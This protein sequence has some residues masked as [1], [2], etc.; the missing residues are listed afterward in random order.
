METSS[1]PS[2]SGQQS[3]R[4]AV[5][6]VAVCGLLLGYFV[7]RTFV[8]PL[9]RQYQLDFGE[10]QWIEPPQFG[11]V[12][13]FRRNI[14]L[15]AVP[16]QAWLELAATDNFEVLINGSTVGNETHVKTRVAGIYDI[17]RHL[18]PGTNVIAVSI[19]R[20]SYPGSAQLL[21]KGAVTEPGGE[22]I[23]IISDE[24]WRVTTKTGIV[25]GSEE[26]SS[27]FVDEALWP[28]AKRATIME[29]RIYIS[30]V[31]LNPLL[32][33]LPTSGNWILSENGG[34]QATFSTSVNA[35][36]AQQETW[37]Q[38]VSSGSLDLL[39]N[40]HLITPADISSSEG[41]QL[42]HLPSASVT[43]EEDG[44][45][46]GSPNGSTL[47]TAPGAATPPPVAYSLRTSS[48]T[49]VTPTPSPFGTTSL[50]RAYSPTSST[51]IPSSSKTRSPI[52][53]S[54]ARSRS[55]KVILYAY[56]ISHWIKKGPNTIVATVRSVD[57]PASFFANGFLVRNDGSVQRFETDSNWQVVQQLST[58]TKKIQHAIE[59]GKDGSAP[60]GYLPQKLA[61]PIDRSGFYN[62]AKACAVFLF[63]MVATA[64]I[65]V[66]ASALVARATGELLR[67][68]L[69]R[70]ALFHAPVIVGL[71]F[72]ILPNYDL[73]F[74]TNW[75]FHP[76]FVIGAML[77]LLAVRLFHFFP[78]RQAIQEI[79][80]RMPRIDRSLLPHALPYLLLAIIMALGLG[81]RCYGLGFMSF[82]HDEMGLISKS[83]GIYKLGFPYSVFAGEIRQ[84]TTYEAVPYPLA[85]SGLIFGHSEWAMRLPSCFM[86]TLC[87]GIIALM[88]RRMF[89]WRTGLIAALVY[90]CMPLNI[91]WAH[92]A[93]YPQQCQFMALLTFWLF[94]E[95]IKVRP[96]QHK[97]L[98]A[99]AVTF[100]LTYL[101]WEGSAFILP[102]LFVGLL[103][104]RW[105]E[106]WWLKEFHLYRCLFFMAAVVIAQYCS[107]TYASY[108]YLMLGSGL[109]NL[110]GPSLFFL[111]PAYQPLYY[112]DNLWLAENHVF[113]TI[114]AL[115]GILFCWG[116]R[117]F[118]Y[119]VA[120]PVTLSF[121][122]TN[123]LAA[124]SPRYCYY[125]QPLLILAGI[126][127]AVLLYDRLRS[128]AFQEGDS[129][130]ARGFAHATGLGLIA[131]LFLQSNESL[132]REY[133]LS[134]RGDDPGLM[135]RMNT[136][137]Y[138][139]R[140]V[141]R[142]VRSQL[143]PGDVLIPG[144]P[145]V[146]EY[147]TGT[148]G[149]YFLDT[150]FASKISYN[151]K[152]A[153]P[154]LADKFR[155]LPAI[156]NLT[157]LQEVTH[158]GGR[159]W[160]ID[161]PAGTSRR[162]QSADVAEYLDQNSKVVFESYRAR[163]ML[164]QGAKQ[165]TGV[166]ASP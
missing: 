20:T 21:V 46:V 155:G 11:P 15:S 45:Q 36:K 96:L 65:W 149:D 164:I 47:P 55:E 140:S 93:F 109:S 17:K 58:P 40:G 51:S 84:A 81:L 76:R 122:H 30:W 61:K 10:A 12:A 127:A 119:V 92:N 95:A 144:I 13:Y 153:E 79:K 74:P 157:E 48:Q 117:Q 125:Y 165:P 99:A 100:C 26:W 72:L 146:I 80:T 1:R 50:S 27:S 135:T 2:G 16:Q 143:Q 107:R 120:V 77:A 145:H 105:G 33:Q 85:L 14:F 139:Y 7:F 103:V 6:M 97:Y 54:N 126:A 5:A 71:V 151:Q 32:L 25:N 29:R 62:V 121:F 113:F 111:N 101:S 142:F 59:A 18:K 114:M 44:E 128:L 19:S 9:P 66:T 91:R 154:R 141:G 118:R 166:A 28:N 82:D 31:D 22:V 106:W 110:A 130:M 159:V 116:N 98:T 162:L 108:P 75:S 150:L 69:F 53:S 42:P 115:I 24:T 43:H 73:R 64:A 160:L 104:V 161:A 35:E 83:Y 94:Y 60:W 63:M 70:D 132:L 49:T 123:F 4:W 131:L 78:A 158:R 67:Y 129:P 87:I 89:D 23:P 124:L 133:T 34:R 147:Y 134:A 156:R 163:V 68:T 152:L 148:P 90:A 102:A 37:I 38:I 3:L 39:V 137:R 136:Y 88:G 52:T 112:I 56:D 57:R 86:G 41:D 8:S 138:D